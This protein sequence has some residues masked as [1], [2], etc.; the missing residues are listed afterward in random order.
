MMKFA[1]SLL[2][3]FA[4]VS[5]YAVDPIAV[6]NGDFTGEQSGFA[7]DLNGNQV[8]D[9]AI[10]IG[11][12]GVRVR[13]TG[14]QNPFGTDQ[15][16]T[17]VQVLVHYSDFPVPSDANKGAVMVSYTG[18]N[19]KTDYLGTC[20]IAG[21]IVRGIWN[22]SQIY[23]GS[24]AKGDDKVTVGS[25][26]TVRS[27][28]CSYTRSA[29]AISGYGKT[30]EGVMGFVGNEIAYGCAALKANYVVGDIMIGG[31]A[32]DAAVF[33]TATGL[34]IHGIAIFNSLNS[35][36]DLAAYEF[37]ARAIPKTEPKMLLNFHK[38]TPVDGWYN[39][40]QPDGSTIPKTGT[41]S[42]NALTF[43][44]GDAGNFFSGNWTRVDS[45]FSAGTYVDIFG[46]EHAD[47]IDEIK[48]SLGLPAAFAFGDDVVKTGLMNGGTAGHTATISGL[49]PAAKYVIYAGFGVVKDGTQCQGFKIQSSGYASVGAREYVTTI[50]GMG[51]RQA[52]SYQ[53]FN[54]NTTIRPGVQ[55]LLVVRLKEVVP[56]SAGTVTFVLDGERGGINW[57]AVAKVNETA[58]VAEI[59]VA[60]DTPASAINALLDESDSRAVLTVAP[61]TTLELD[62]PFAVPVQLVSSGSVT[63]NAASCPA[64]AELAKLDI[65]GVQ[66]T[67]VRT[68]M[69]RG[70]GFNFAAGC[71]PKTEKALVGETDWYENGKS[72]NATDFVF[73]D[74]L[75]KI[76]YTSAN[77][78]NDAG[79]KDDDANGTL[80]KGY[81]DDGSGVNITVKGIPYPEYAVLIYASTDDTTNPNLT[82]KRVN[83]ETYTYDV[84]NPE[85]AKIGTAAWGQG[86]LS[87][88]PTYGKNV[89]RIVAQKG[90]TLTVFSPREIDSHQARGCVSAIQIVPYT[91]VV[92]PSFVPGRSVSVAV[93]TDP[94]TYSGGQ[95]TLTIPDGALDYG[96]YAED[97]I[98]YK[99]LFA[100]QPEILTGSKTA[101]GTVV[102]SLPEADYLPGNVYR[103]QIVLDYGDGEIDVAKAT[104]YEGEP[105]RVPLTDWINE[106]PTTFRT[107]GTWTSGVSVKD[108]ALVVESSTGATFTPVIDPDYVGGCDSTFTVR[109]SA[110]EAVDAATDTDSLDGVQG[111]VRL[112]SIGG[113]L[114]L[115]VV[116]GGVWTELAPASVATGYDVTVTFHYMQATEKVDTVT[117]AWNGH[118]VVDAKSAAAP[119]TKVTEVFVADGTRL[120]FLKGICDL[121]KAVVLDVEIAPG[122]ER[123]L[124]AG[125][126][127]SA[128]ALAAKM[129]VAIADE[130]ASKLTTK[131]LQEQYRGYF[132]IV[133]KPGTDGKFHAVVDFVPGVE[134]EIEEELAG[135]LEKVVAGFETGCAEIAAKPGLYYGLA[136][137]DDVQD[138]SVKDKLDLA[139]ADGKVKIT[140]VRPEGKTKHFYRLIC[141]PIAESL[142]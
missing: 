84:T 53:S 136:R 59:D 34:K 44:A 132:K 68:W 28:V 11:T 57:L 86:R 99:L 94:K 54:E 108:G 76:T 109:I 23:T 107:T 48:T 51:T 65:S 10:T 113:T 19:G 118:T 39:H 70:V 138:L 133:A 134:A 13:W 95:V 87:A 111:G 77:I 92:P 31:K 96:T 128:D 1:V 12:S 139:G 20:V 6:W 112:A 45:S 18:A 130:V 104:V 50:D 69:T 82:Y 61:G 121:D 33:L 135:A 71:G 8:Q 100:G 60:D 36:A 43:A 32:G 63:L 52:T 26:A 114:Q 140:I 131:A 66:G 73:G 3:L 126:Q 7:L 97:A 16:A 72:E 15:N 46:N 129:V 125:D 81:L 122:D 64:A 47:L 120:G 123:V 29:D 4:S 74:G 110:D 89:L 49:S 103:G 56:T 88:T 79:S 124:S 2:A 24:P 98:S 78:Y 93:E 62:A 58:T 21:G 75:M 9:G 37:P 22:N 80:V 67:L 137:G 41:I 17:K 127:A 42:T 141:S 105:T 102:F 91:T 117:Y 40:T 119:Q 142:P 115:Q 38:D 14:A 101:D 55:G 25:D 90:P 85:V 5:L 27:F 106:T 116:K 83:G 30:Y 35:P